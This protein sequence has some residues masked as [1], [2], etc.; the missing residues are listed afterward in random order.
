MQSRVGRDLT[1]PQQAVVIWTSDQKSG[2]KTFYSIVNAAIRADKKGAILN[3]SAHF[4]RAL[5]CHLVL[6]NNP[7]ALGEVELPEKVFRGTWMP[8]KQVR[9][10]RERHGEDFRAVQLVATSDRRYV[11]DN[12]LVT[13]DQS[14]LRHIPIRFE[15]SMG[16]RPLHVRLLENLTSSQ[17][18]REWLFPAYSSFQVAER[19]LHRLEFA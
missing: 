17:G 1:L 2:G 5:N 18:E 13:Y 4:C 8:E 7:V 14:H 9:W 10:F 6:R 15:I 3:L 11:A 12:F 16:S 19:H